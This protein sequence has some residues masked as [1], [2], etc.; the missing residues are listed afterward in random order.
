LRRRLPERLAHQGQ[1]RCDQDR[2]AG[3]RGRLRRAAGRQHDE[4]T[5]YPAAFESSW[6][7]KEL[8]QAKNFK[9]WFKKGRTTATLMTGIEQWLLPKL[10]IRNPPWTLHRESRTTC[11]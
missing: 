3:R 6:L 7:H 8:L 2:H 1:P 4:L 11:T 5:A 9:Q 10:G